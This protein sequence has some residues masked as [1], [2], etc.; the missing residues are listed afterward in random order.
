M[1]GGE[2][3]KISKSD[4]YGYGGG[5]T[6]LEYDEAPHAISGA[7]VRQYGYPEYSNVSEAV[8]AA[9]SDISERQGG[10]SGLTIITNNELPM[11][12]SF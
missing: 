6:R 11:T 3:D 10:T 1:T 9:I 7:A 8:T 5:D 4:G 2:N 12:P